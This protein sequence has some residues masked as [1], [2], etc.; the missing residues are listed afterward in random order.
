MCENIQF[1]PSDEYVKPNQPQ[2]SDSELD[3]TLSQLLM[4][5][6]QQKL[7]QKGPSPLSWGHNRGAVFQE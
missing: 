1:N 3:S 7:S 4:T 2:H 5:Y 6:T